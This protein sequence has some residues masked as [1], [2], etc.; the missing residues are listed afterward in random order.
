MRK[1]IGYA[2]KLR[3][4]K[5]GADGRMAKRKP[6]KKGGAAKAGEKKEVRREKKSCVRSAE[7]C[8]SSRAARRPGESDLGA[9]KES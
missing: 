4:S 2:E 7:S 1:R 5:C 6:R 3:S 9:E 8:V